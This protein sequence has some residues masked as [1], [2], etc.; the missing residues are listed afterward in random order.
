[1]PVPVL[2]NLLIP[3]PRGRAFRRVQV[4]GA[5]ESSAATRTD[6]YASNEFSIVTTQ[7]G[8]YQRSASGQD[9]Q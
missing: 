7:M 4:L 5:G 1:M 2:L 8:P 3:V 9:F 6:G